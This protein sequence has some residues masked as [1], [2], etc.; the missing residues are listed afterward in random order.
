MAFFVTL[1]VLGIKFVK[2]KTRFILFFIFSTITILYIGYN[3]SSVFKVRVDETINE[4]PVLFSD[5]DNIYRGDIGAR[6][7]VWI[8][9]EEL[10]KDDIITGIGAGSIHNKIANFIKIQNNPKFNIIKIRSTHNIYINFL[11]MLGIIG[12]ILYLLI[13]YYLIKLKFDEEF[14]YYLNI[15]FVSTY[16]IVGLTE[17]LFLNQFPMNLFALFVG[18]LILK[19]QKY[20]TISNEIKYI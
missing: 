4:I 11:L 2:N 20:K 9:S 1:I 10:I 8:I 17:N 16:C 14:F 12:F 18:I 6:I 19:S 3:T 7:G 5:S 15:I 13:W